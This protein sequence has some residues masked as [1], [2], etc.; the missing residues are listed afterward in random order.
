MSDGTDGVKTTLVPTDTP[1]RTAVS[2][3]DPYCNLWLG[4]PFATLFYYYYYY[5][6]R[7]YLLRPTGPK[8]RATTRLAAMR[9]TQTSRR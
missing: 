6:S 5:Y 2:P 9:P 7:T 4:G 8:I 3:G 1:S